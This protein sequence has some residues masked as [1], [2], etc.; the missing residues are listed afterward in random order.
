MVRSGANFHPMYI[1]VMI[2]RDAH[3]SLKSMVYYL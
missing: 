2:V 3:N 1:M